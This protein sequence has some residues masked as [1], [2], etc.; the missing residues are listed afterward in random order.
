MMTSGFSTNDGTFEYIYYSHTYTH[1]Y[2]FITH[3]IEIQNKNV[4][5]NCTRFFLLSIALIKTTIVVMK[6]LYC[7][8]LDM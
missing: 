6:K 3:I 8:R 2:C 7:C 4:T 1:V 5:K